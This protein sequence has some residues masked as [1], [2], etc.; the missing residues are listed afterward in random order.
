MYSFLLYVNFKKE[1]NKQI[2]K[3][4]PKSLGVTWALLKTEKGLFPQ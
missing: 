3:Y 4:F 1:K 2:S